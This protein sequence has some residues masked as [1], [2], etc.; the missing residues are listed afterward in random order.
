[1][2]PVDVVNLGPSS[3]YAAVKPPEVI[4]WSSAA[5]TVAV[6]TVLLSSPAVNMLRK[7]VFI[8]ISVTSLMWIKA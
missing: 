1:V 5:C 3:L 7:K 4:T 6:A 2:L 8:R